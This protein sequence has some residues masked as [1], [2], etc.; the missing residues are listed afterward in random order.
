MKKLQSFESYNPDFP[1]RFQS[2]GYT[3]GPTAMKILLDFIKYPEVSVDYLEKVS[4]TDDVL[5]CTDVGMSKMLDHLGIKYDRIVDETEQNSFDKLD[6][7]LK[8]DKV[9]LRTLTK[10]VKHWI[11]VY[12]K[13]GNVY[14]CSDPWLGLISYDKDHINYIWAPRKYDAFLVTTDNERPK[15]EK[16]E[17]ED[18]PEIIRISKDIFK[19]IIGNVDWMDEYLIESTNF[20]ISVKLT[21]NGQIIGCYLL[22]PVNIKGGYLKQFPELAGLKGLEG[23]C[24]G[25][26]PLY[27]SM[28][29][30]KMLL[31]YAE[32]LNYDYMWGEH[33]KSLNNID[34]WTKRRDKVVDFGE[35]FVSV[36][37]K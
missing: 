16:I 21:M 15:V 22:N 32:N 33:L 25:I 7:H 26:I 28:G 1:H 20:D 35:I 37:K 3:C 36:K 2:K 12:D 17:K 24:L 31:A 5:G 30:G 34:H 9:I 10:G 18:I 11:V 4:G 14:K 29:Y 13:I 8:N 6:Q 27:K 23:V 19:T